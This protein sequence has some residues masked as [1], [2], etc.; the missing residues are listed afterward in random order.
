MYFVLQA[1]GHAGKNEVKLFERIRWYSSPGDMQR[2]R[3][4]DFLIRKLKKKGHN[5]YV[6]EIYTKNP[7]YKT[8]VHI[9]YPYLEHWAEVPNKFEDLFKDETKMYIRCDGGRI[10]TA[11]EADNDQDGQLCRFV[12]PNLFVTDLPKGAVVKIDGYGEGS[13]RS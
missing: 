10:Y 6:G 13:S 8:P 9:Q 3:S 1:S 2:T 11:Q 4:E 5:Y 7:K 12:I